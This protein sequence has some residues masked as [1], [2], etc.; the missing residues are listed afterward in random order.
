MWFN[1]V[2]I[3]INLTFG[4][5]LSNWGHNSWYLLVWYD[6][7]YYLMVRKLLRRFELG[8]QT[9]LYNFH[10]Q[11]WDR[12]KNLPYYLIAR[13]NTADETNA[14]ITYTLCN[15][16][17]LIRQHLILLLLK[18]KI[19]LTCKFC[20]STTILP[21]RIFPEKII[22][23]FLYTEKQWNLF[24]EHCRKLNSFSYFKT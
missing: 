16:K 3:V 20:S 2:L 19:R 23:L 9:I 13:N 21:W 17:V 15:L 10:K 22:E 18:M 7:L 14:Y 24:M 8:L 1:L 6:V 12:L 11:N 4:I 5:E